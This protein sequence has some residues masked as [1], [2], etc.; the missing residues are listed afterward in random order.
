MKNFEEWGMSFPVLK[1]SFPEEIAV[2]NEFS[3]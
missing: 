3:Q 2:E 1:L